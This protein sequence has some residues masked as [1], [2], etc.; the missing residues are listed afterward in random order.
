MSTSA[1]H[2]I[3]NVQL[4]SVV[5]KSSV[6]S[7]DL[8]NLRC[9]STILIDIIITTTVLLLSTLLFR[10]TAG[11]SGETPA[12]LTQ[13]VSI[14]DA[15]REKSHGSFEHKRPSEFSSATGVARNLQ[16]EMSEVRGHP[17]DSRRGEV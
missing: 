5:R 2:Q 12:D 6:I 16:V 9:K 8:A 17:C 10:R 7:L 14:L 13:V 4:F 15:F 1:P 3:Q 11:I